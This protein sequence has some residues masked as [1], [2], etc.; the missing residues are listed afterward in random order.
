M[1][2]LHRLTDRFVKTAKPSDGRRQQKFPDGAGLYLQVSESNSD[3]DEF[4]RSWAFLYERHGQR[5]AVGL[6]PSHSLSLAEARAKAR[7]LRQQ[8][9]DGI[10]PLNAKRERER[11]AMQKIAAASAV[12]TFTKATEM[13]LDAHGGKWGNSKHA[14]QWET[15]LRETFPVLGKFDVNHITTEHVVAALTP[16]FKDKPDTASR[17]RGRVEAVLGYCIAS[18]FRKDDSN[19]ARWRGHLATIFGVKKS[20]TKHHPALPFAELP[21]LMAR[22]RDVDTVG[23][24]ALELVILTA[25]RTGDVLGMRWDQDQVNL[26]DGI[27]TIPRTKTGTAHAVPLCGRAVQ[28]LRG[29][30]RK[31]G[32]GGLVFWSLHEK[33]MDNTLKRLQPDVTVH[34]MRSAFR[35]W[36]GDATNY[37][38]EV[39]EAAL[40]HKVGNAVEAAYRRG[41]A[42]E[43]RRK[44]MDAWAAFLSKP[45][46]AAGDKVVPIGRRA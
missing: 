30:P 17:L 44:L 19:P 24:R 37:P 10:D 36:C 43:K 45:T 35:D 27:W 14:K 13:Y 38:R 16:A 20:Q 4:N 26:K 39:A 41:S 25:T 18:G 29:L 40:A 12:V 32:G 11:E 15:T 2:K 7:G 46:T 31:S 34:G 3:P 8:L 42:F 1:R 6:G 33:T 28:I 21:S 5:H 22:L 9:L 23:A